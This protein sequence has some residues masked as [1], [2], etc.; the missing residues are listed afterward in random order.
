MPRLM[1]RYR[2]FWWMSVL[3]FPGATAIAQE[4]WATQA[5]D[6]LTTIDGF[7]ER[8]EWAQYRITQD[9]VRVLCRAAVKIGC[10]SN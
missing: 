10:S 8:R 7:N 4:Q 2:R 9:D 5:A 3:L 6:C 1:P